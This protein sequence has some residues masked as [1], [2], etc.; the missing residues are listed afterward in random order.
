MV[1]THVGN[2]APNPNPTPAQFAA[3]AVGDTVTLHA[4]SHP[5]DP[6]RNVSGKQGAL[7][8]MQPALCGA[9]AALPSLPGVGWFGL[10]SHPPVFS[11]KTVWP[12]MF[13][14]PKSPKMVGQSVSQSVQDPPRLL[15]FCPLLIRVTALTPKWRQSP[16][17]LPVQSCALH[18]L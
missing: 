12:L 18:S 16:Y 13:S 7:P 15:L 2:T 10:S 6:P 1:W 3:L 17:L 4:I 9:P 11:P 14:S 8:E 5:A